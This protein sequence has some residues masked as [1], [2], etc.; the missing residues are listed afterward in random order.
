[1][2]RLVIYKGTAPVQLSHL[3]TRPCH[4][5]VNQAFSPRLRLDPRRP[6]NGDGFG[7]GWYD[8]VYDEELGAQPCIFT[9]LTPAWNNGNL[10]RLAEK[11]KSPLVFGHVRATTSGSLSPDNCHPFGF[12]KLMW[13]HNG[14]IAEFGKIRRKLQGSLSDGIFDSV[15]G[16]TDSEWAFAL[17]LSK[18]PDPNAKSFTFQMLRD[19]MLS[20]IATINELHEDAGITEPSLMNFCVTDGESVVATR[21]ISSKKDAAASLWFSSGTSFSEYAPG[22]HYKMFKEDKREN[23]IMVASEP[24]TFEKADW[25]EVKTNNMIIL[26]PKMNVLLIP[27]IDKFY[28]HPSDPRSQNRGTD[29]AAA[30]GLFTERWEVPGTS[31]PESTSLQQA[32][33]V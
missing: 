29:L 22:G 24:L 11:I 31:T 6:I 20:T 12:G 13:M 5:I 18:L 17:F 19:A 1:M 14:E 10:V 2:C 21:Y 23:I 30:K 3:L 27:I 32:L 28:V 26:T 9:S 15:K 33:P 25:M 7:V 16:N 4:S 8:S